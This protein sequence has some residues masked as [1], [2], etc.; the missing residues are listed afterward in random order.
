MKRTPLV[1][2]VI[3]FG[4]CATL[5]TSDDAASRYQ[6]G[7][8]ALARRDYV[9]AMP[10]LEHVSR[11]ASPE[12]ARRATLLLVLAGLDPANP[13]RSPA[14]A[15]TIDE[16]FGSTASTVDGGADSPVT[17]EHVVAA[18]LKRLA[19][20]TADL[21]QGMAAAQTQRDGAFGSVTQLRVQL[22][23]M[24]AERD[25]VRRKLTQ[26]ELSSAEL[27]KELQKKTAE[28]ERIRRIIRG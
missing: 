22:D 16:R 6:E 28:L 17:F 21:Q 4:A 3:A 14:A 8:D 18:T 25:S 9:S 19:R 15:G 23:S 10:L 13:A 5:R 7:L 2:A 1:L 11:T 12:E 24:T 20:E 26:L 27:E